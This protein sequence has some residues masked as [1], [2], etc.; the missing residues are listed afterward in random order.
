TPG[1]TAT[2]QT[3]TYGYS[4]DQLT[5]V[6]SPLSASKCTT[7]GYTSGSQYRNASLDLDPHGLWQLAET[8]GTRAKD[9]V[10]ANQGTDDATYEH[11]TLGAAGPFSGSR[12]A[13]F[14]GATSDVV[15]PD[16]LGNDTDSGALSLWFKTSAGPGVLYSY[17]SQPITSGEAAGFYTPAL[18]VGKDGK[19]N[20]EFWYSGGINP[21]V[22]S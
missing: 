3:W 5:K 10:L 9:A 18:Y 1:D 6:C 22:T 16:N 21:I 4:G 11:V 2:A 13:T 20:A 12:G 14:D 8:S 19:L 7:Y 15:L 17:A